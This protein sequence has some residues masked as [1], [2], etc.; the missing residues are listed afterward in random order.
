MH[1]TFIAES[2]YLVLNSLWGWEPVKKLKQRGDIVSFLFFFSVG[3]EQ[4]SSECTASYRQRKQADHK[5]GSCS[6]G[7]MTELQ[8]RGH[9]RV[10]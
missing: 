7:R 1:D 9:D 5:G 3:G 10:R 4:H 8:W 2:V 6:G